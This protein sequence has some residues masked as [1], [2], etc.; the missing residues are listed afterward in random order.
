MLSIYAVPMIMRPVDFLSN[1]GGYLVG[2][3]SYIVLIPMF[4]NVFSIY[5]FSNLHDVSWGNRPSTTGV[6]TEA[7]SA[8]VA[9]QKKTE[10]SYMTFR[11]NV[12]FIWIACNG[13][14]FFIVLRLTGSSDPML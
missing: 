3:V 7:F 1:L 4:V 2:L 5:S 8:N 11:A 12:L 14:Y 9:I 10:E 6:G 13:A